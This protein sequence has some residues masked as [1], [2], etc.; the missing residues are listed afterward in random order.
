MSCLEH[1]LILHQHGRESPPLLLWWS[2]MLPAKYLQLSL[3]GPWEGY[4]SL[5]PCSWETNELWDKCCVYAVMDIWLLVWDSP[6]SS[7]PSCMAA[8]DTVNVGCSISLSLW[9]TVKSRGTWGQG[10]RPEAALPTPVPGPGNLRPCP[11]PHP[12]VAW[13]GT[14]SCAPI[15]W[16]L[17]GVGS[18]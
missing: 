5:S 13:Q 17:I 11:Q 10:R 9:I 6:E 14:W 16:G 4:T 15:L 2:L 3:L 18:V 7:F 12:N 8:Q 1:F